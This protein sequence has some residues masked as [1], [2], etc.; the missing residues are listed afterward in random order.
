MVSRLGGSRRRAVARAFA[1]GAV[2]ASAALGF[3][4]CGLSVSATGGPPAEPGAAAEAGDTGA[5]RSDGGEGG[6]GGCTPDRF[7]CGGA[8]TDVKADPQ[9]CGA[10]GKICGE[11]LTCDDGN[12]T[13]L[14]VS[15]KKDCNGTCVDT[16]SDVLHCGSCPNACGAGLLCSAGRCATDCGAL[17]TCALPDAGADAGPTAVYC[18]D[19]TGDRNN[20]GA[21]G[22]VCKGNEICT[23]SACKALCAT[24]SRIG[25]IFATNMVGCVQKVAWSS[26]AQVCPAGSKVCT[27]QEW[28]TRRGAKIPTYHYWTDDDLRWSGEDGDCVASTTRG[29]LCGNPATPMRV[30]AKT[31]DPVGN[32]CNWTGCGFGNATK[33]PQ[34]FGGCEGNPTAGALCC[35]P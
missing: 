20:C 25:E 18:A 2:L 5:A 11:G 34:Y 23:A 7:M 4:A 31:T 32:K 13:V 17:S 19:L 28:V 10:C 26:R 29:Q 27:G 21:C 15:D 35:T 30:C 22:N 12:C 33:P 1:C 8:C 14:C 6:Q 24:T 9:N 16:T 3:A